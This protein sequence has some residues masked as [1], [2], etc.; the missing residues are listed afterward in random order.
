MKI[1]YVENHPHFITAV[2]K[3]FLSGHEVFDFP[4]VA[5][6][7]Q[8]FGSGE[9]DLVLSDYD[10]DEGKGSELVAAIRGKNKLI[11]IIAVSSHDKGNAEM[12]EAGANAECSK[13]AF[14]ELAN[15]IQTVFGN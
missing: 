6:A 5:G 14:R 12:L 2:R 8:A 15:V 4:T 11:P 7:L 1:L 3:E 9:Y 13:M 10:L